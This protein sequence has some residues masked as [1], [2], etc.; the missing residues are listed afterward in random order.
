[1]KTVFDARDKLVS[2]PHDIEHV[3]K[4]MEEYFEVRLQLHLLN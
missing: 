1:M 3:R 4:A 2:P